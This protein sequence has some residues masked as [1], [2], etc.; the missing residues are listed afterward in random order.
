[1]LYTQDLV[2]WSAP[3]QWT[4]LVLAG[5]SLGIAAAILAALIVRGNRRLFLGILVVLSTTAAST[6]LGL[7]SPGLL[8]ETPAWTP[9]RESAFYQLQVR[10]V[11]IPSDLL[12]RVENPLSGE[13]STL[14][15]V[16]PTSQDSFLMVSSA[17]TEIFDGDW[18]DYKTNLVVSYWPNMEK[19]VAQFDVTSLEPSLTLARGVFFD[20]AREAIYISA[21]PRN[22]ECTGLEL[23]RISFA[24]SERKFGKPE[25]I[26]KSTPCLPG[27]SGY[28]QFGGR[29]AQDN[30]GNIL[31]SVGDFANGVST[32]REEAQDG[33]YSGRPDVLRDPSTYGVV[34]QVNQDGRYTILSHGHRN[35]Q[36]LHYDATLGDLWLSE[37]GPKGGDELNL[38]SAGLDY[39]WPDVTY[40]GPYGGGPQP[41]SSWN[42]GRW[43]G[44][45]HGQFVEP[46]LTWLPAIAASQLL[47]YRGVLFDQWRGDI[48]LASF[49]G[50]IHRIRIVDDRVLF[51]EVIEIGTRPR[52][53]VE[54][55]DGSLLISTDDNRLM[56]VR[57]HVAE[58]E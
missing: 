9:N 29:I 12:A 18:E 24:E 50:A 47:V 34:V 58:S 3:S 40:G 23:W 52:D 2:S 19:P 11:D 51:D 49:K 13:R 33:P 44:T 6:G 56:T 39:G 31:L 17:G 46:V 38:I 30:E 25:R 27:S 15:Y 36:G 14:H 28:Q 22:T 21:I 32:V 7:V 45:N 54:M 10:E 35:P 1:V 55:P 42:F 57:P 8:G 26:F 43:F 48:L 5:L 37:H 4:P 41:D 16:A 20:Q 53:L